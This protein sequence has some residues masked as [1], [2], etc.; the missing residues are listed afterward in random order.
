[1]RWVGGHSFTSGASV[2]RSMFL[3]VMEIF[4]RGTFAHLLLLRA[5]IFLISVNICVFLLFTDERVGF[6]G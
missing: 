2:G 6:L 1:M 3:L 5:Y 4:P